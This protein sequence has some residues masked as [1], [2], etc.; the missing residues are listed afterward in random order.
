MLGEE[1][2]RYTY[3][4]LLELAL[5]KV[6]DNVDKREGSVIYDALAPACYVLAEFFEQL[7]RYTQETFAD[8]ATG[9]WLDKRVNEAGI[10]RNPASVAVKKAVFTTD[11]GSPATVPI[12]SRFA[13]IDAEVPLYYEITEEY[14]VDGEVVPGAYRA[15]CESA[16]AAGHQYFGTIVPLDFLPAIATATLTDTLV[17]GED[18]ETDESV[19]ERYIAKINNKAFAGNVA[20]YR[21]MTLSI[22][23][24][25]GVQVYPV[26]NGGGT[27]K[28]SIVDGTFSRASEDFVKT[29]QEIIDPESIPEYAGTGLG[30]AP[31]DH[32]VTVVTPD[33]YK[34]NIS[35]T[36][37]LSSGYTLAQVRSSIVTALD[38]YFWDLRRSWDTGD[39]LNRYSLTIY[40]AQIV[41]VALNVPGVVNISNVTINGSNSDIV[42]TQSG[43][44]QQLPI[45]GEVSLSESA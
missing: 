37:T 42:L 38:E 33:E 3:E 35:G 32:R 20:H 12:G 6:P 5:L 34:A 24:I 39:E 18:V 40:Q 7:Y 43:T 31:I 14:S 19:L 30:M 23:G 10:T 1:L 8:T 13:T 9:E 21:E 11:N 45:L 44:V 36:I 22:E 2:Q 17:P 15:T 4:Y 41:R 27:V 29:V 16:G 25:G 26:W 28:L